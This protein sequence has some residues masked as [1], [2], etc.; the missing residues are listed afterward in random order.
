MK[1]LFSLEINR[2]SLFTASMQK[3]MLMLMLGLIINIS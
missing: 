2:I 1:Y 3:A